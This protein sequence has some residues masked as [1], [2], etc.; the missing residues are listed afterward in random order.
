MRARRL[1]QHAL[2]SLQTPFPCT[3]R[4]FMARRIS[5]SFKSVRDAKSYFVSL[6]NGFWATPF[7]SMSCDSL[8]SVEKSGRQK[9]WKEKVHPAFLE[10]ARVHRNSHETL[11]GSAPHQIAR[12][13]QKLRAQEIGR[14][15]CRERV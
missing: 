1:A 4:S 9:S 11:S 10:I 7:S 14:A 15:S 2:C 12:H 6:T 8:S 13:A 3:K 5:C